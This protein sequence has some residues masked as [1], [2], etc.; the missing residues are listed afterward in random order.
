MKHILRLGALAAAVSLL[1]ACGGGSS[2]APSPGD[3]CG[4]SCNAT[5]SFRF[6]PQ[7][8]RI[9]ANPETFDIEFPDSPYITQLTV[10]AQRVD[11]S[12]V[13]ENTL[14]TLSSSNTAVAQVNTTDLGIYGARFNTACA[15]TSGGLAQF[16]VLSG[17][18]PGQVRLTASMVEPFATGT[19]TVD[20]EERTLTCTQQV[21]AGGSRTVSGEFIYTVDP[22]QSL[23]PRVEMRP[24]RSTLP[25]NSFGF[26]PFVGSPFLTEV[27][28]IRRRVNGQIILS[29]NVALTLTPTDTGAISFPNTGANTTAFQTLVVGGNVPVAGGRGLFYAHS[30]DRAGSFFITASAVD[31]DSGRPLQVTREFRVQAAGSPNPAEIRFI[32]DDTPVYIQ[33]AGGATTR[34][35]QVLVT[36]GTSAP[37]A[38]ANGV[39]NVLLEIATPG[40]AGGEQVNAVGATG[41]A[42]GTSIRART[43]NG[44]L[45]SVFRS[46]T[47]QGSITLRATADRADNNV[48]NGIQ[49]PVSNT[50]TLIV[51]DGRLFSI[52]LVRPNDAVTT[53][54]NPVNPDA[55][56]PVNPEALINRQA[57]TYRMV[58]I[59]LA[60]DRQGNPV[61]PGT[62]LEFGLIDSP[63]VGYPDLG[64][65]EFVIAGLDGDPQEGGTLFTAPSGNF[66]TG[67]G[68]AGP[69]DTLVVFGEQFAGN[70]DL[71]SAR[72]VQSILSQSSLR[73]TTRF[74]FNDDTGSTVNN[75]PVL[76]YAIGRATIANIESNTVP[77]TQQ[78]VPTSTPVRV[79]T[80]AQGLA[81]TFVNYPISQLNRRVIIWARGQG[82]LV[83]GSPELVTDVADLVF[84][85]FGL[86][87]RLVVTPRTIR[88]NRVVDVD[89]C[90]YDEINTPLPAVIVNFSFQRLDG[91]GTV[92]GVPNS[93]RVARATGTNGCT[94]ARVETRG[95]LSTSTQLTFDIRRP[96]SDGQ[97]SAPE[98]VVVT[99][100]ASGTPILQAIPTELFG[101]G[102]TVRLRLLG[103]EGTPIQGVQIA[104]V[105]DAP[106][107]TTGTGAT[108]AGATAVT[109]DPRISITVP[110]GVTN[111]QGET[112]ATIVS[113]FDGFGR[114]AT[115]VCT[116]SVPA[117]NAQAVQV[118]VRG[119]NLCAQTPR[120]A[121]CGALPTP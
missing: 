102:G 92:D 81:Q 61:I 86:Q 106:T 21:P 114:F 47:R 70:R 49:N 42:E 33:G 75:G 91:S 7:K 13:Q 72:T 19:V 104:G 94:V 88:G 74:N 105:C 90:V 34:Q 40:A 53:P 4:F 93:G 108:A 3:T 48:D 57:G 112:T 118:T 85:G 50:V 12:P 30:R 55:L 63:V 103:Q 2:G 51:S 41:A 31:P 80:N 120:P 119:T 116:F 66:Q 1:S 35:F 107:L 43:I 5:S 111:A 11:G 54:P 87:P 59:A 44:V 56:N 32:T 17:T 64:Q 38:D 101:N 78:G 73:T 29:D 115:A 76:P 83:Q 22:A 10:R 84:A 62:P 52:K 24:I 98:P 67:G 25:I 117:G 26:T 97:S 9:P 18:L 68:G 71:E 28:V 79:N 113:N 14:I 23:P 82:D 109:P 37:V 46:G 15:L 8:A 58:V 99:I 69:G 39:N 95:L 60:T 89:I 65:G 36:D 96:A 45:A 77:P 121:A 20:A 16:Y 100:D 27:E 110:P 6:E